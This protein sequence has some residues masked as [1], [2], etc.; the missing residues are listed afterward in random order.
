MKTSFVLLLLAAGCPA[1]PDTDA[2]A[3]TG[4]T[5]DTDRPAPSETGPT[6]RAVV[7]D[8]KDIFAS[9]AVAVNAAGQLAGTAAVQVGDAVIITAY[10]FEEGGE[11]VFATHEGDAAFATAI[12]ADGTVAGWVRGMGEAQGLLFDGAATTLLGHI[13]G[14]GT[15]ARAISGGRV[16]GGCEDRFHSEQICTWTA[17]Q[18]WKAGDF[19]AAYGIT[20]EAEI[21][22]LSGVEGWAYTAGPDLALEPLWPGDPLGNVAN[23]VS[24]G[25]RFVAGK[26]YVRLG[27][28]PEPSAAWWIDR[29]TGERRDVPATDAVPF[30]EP[31]SEAFGVSDEGVAVGVG[32]GGD[33]NLV[34]WIYDPWLGEVWNLEDRL[35]EPLPDGMELVSARGIAGGYV[36]ATGLRSDGS[37]AGVLLVP[38][39]GASAEPEAAELPEAAAQYTV[40]PL[41]PEGTSWAVGI[42]ADGVAYGR[43]TRGMTSGGSIPLT[44]RVAGGTIELFP[45]AEVVPVRLGDD[46]VLV[47]HGVVGFDVN[48]FRLHADGPEDLG[49]PEGSP[50]AFTY[51]AAG[52]AVL[53]ECW[54]DGWR[55]C[56]RTELGW[57]DLGEGRAL[58][59]AGGVIVGGDDAGSLLWTASGGVEPLPGSLATAISADARWVTGRGE[60]AWALD[61]ETDTTW[62]LDGARRIVPLDVSASGVVVGQAIGSRGE[63]RAFRWAPG[64]LQITLLDP[65]VASDLRLVAARAIAPDGRIVADALDEAGLHRAVVLTPQP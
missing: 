22:G 24:P 29:E 59:G 54:L 57:E 34:A 14:R 47:G 60:A 39:D 56:R 15:R 65:I 4:D 43:F 2:P 19:G 52:D 9:D 44:G 35:V 8:H 55:V 23:A 28:G 32:S 18:G 11:P 48:A 45:L 13:D 10:R 38:V 50:A 26:R 25:G 63:A 6:Y 3:D 31:W 5:D 27:I 7:V 21:V 30:R 41:D 46:G 1:T 58:D 20:E 53:G 33:G 40:T 36:A 61:R 16:A 12:D 37:T 64:D 49:R 42:D 51:A 17:E 62:E